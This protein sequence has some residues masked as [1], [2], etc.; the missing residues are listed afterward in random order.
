M[1]PTPP[2]DDFGDSRLRDAEPA[3]QVYVPL[4]ISRA[5]NCA[6]GIFVEF[7]IPVAA[8]PWG[9]M[10]TVAKGMATI[11]RVAHL[12]QVAQAIVVLHA[13]AVIAHF[14]R[15][16]GTQKRCNHQAVNAEL[17]DVTL[18]STR[19]R[20]LE[21]ATI[22]SH[23]LEYAAAVTRPD[24]SGCRRPYASNPAEVGRLVPA[25]VIGDGS[26]VFNGGC[27][28]LRLHRKV[29]FG[30]MRSDAPRVAAAL[31][32]SHLA[33]ACNGLRAVRGLA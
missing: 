32:I 33:L 5:T 28:R 7:S 22:V 11:H 9:P 12:F 25:F 30:A 4:P 10:Q 3:S 17:S 18:T 16:E 29:P 23:G 24:T 13:I 14:A 20:H 15:S 31:I 21:I 26:P 2:L 27:D 19:E 1:L 6:D 8:A